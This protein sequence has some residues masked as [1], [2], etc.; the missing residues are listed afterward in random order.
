MTLHGAI[1]IKSQNKN[2]WQKHILPSLSS[3]FPSNP[4]TKKNTIQ[5]KKH[6]T[7]DN[8]KKSFEKKPIRI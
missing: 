2:I 8:Q 1:Q 4:N 7:S 6:P 3:L 5:Q